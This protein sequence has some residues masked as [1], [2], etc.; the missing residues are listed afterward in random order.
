M[1]IYPIEYHCVAIYP[2]G[3]HYT[4]IYFIRYYCMAIYFRAVFHKFTHVRAPAVFRYV[5]VVV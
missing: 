1:A 5:K 3:Y 2:I 4:A